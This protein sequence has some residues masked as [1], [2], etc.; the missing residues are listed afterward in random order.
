MS[1]AGGQFEL[2]NIR[3]GGPYRLEITYVGFDKVVRENIFVSLGEV[4]S[5]DINME[6]KVKTTQ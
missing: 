2:S 1:R 3:S 5:Q 4:S 6:E